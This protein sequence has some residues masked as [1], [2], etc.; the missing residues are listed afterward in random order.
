MVLYSFSKSI[1]SK[2]GNFANLLIENTSTIY[3]AIKARSEL[4]RC[5]QFT[6]IVFSFT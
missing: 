1:E 6:F 5:S 3:F 4:S 2:K